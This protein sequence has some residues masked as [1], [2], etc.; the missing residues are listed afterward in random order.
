MRVVGTN[1][2][3]RHL[4]GRWLIGVA[5]VERFDQ[6]RDVFDN[7]IGRLRS[8][9]VVS[10]PLHDVAKACAAS[11]S[12]AIDFRVYDLFDFPFFDS[13]Y[14]DWRR[15]CLA[16]EAV[17]VRGRGGQQVVIEYRVDLHRRREVES[18]G[19]RLYL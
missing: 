19:I 12:P 13:F 14:F 18:A 5:P 15:G 17:R 16:L 8:R 9:D 10:L 11:A 1:R 4:A 6:V 3:T 7:S 2:L